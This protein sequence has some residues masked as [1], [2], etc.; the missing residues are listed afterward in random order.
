MI[1]KFKEYLMTQNKSHSTIEG[2]IRSIKDYF[3]WFSHS[4]GKE[5]TKLIKQNID[6][7]RSYLQ[8]IKRQNAK[9]INYKLSSLKKYNEFLVDS[10]IQND[11]IITDKMM[12]KVQQEYASPATITEKDVNQLRQAILEQGSKRDYAL[13]NLLAYTGLRISEAL[14][15]PLSE[16][17]NIYQT[18]ELMIRNGKGNKQRTVY[19]NDKVLSSLKDYI[20]NERSTYKTALDSTF[21][22]VSNKNSC[23]D[24]ITVNKMLDKYCKGAK[25]K[26][27]TPH[28]LR[29]F[30]C[31]HALEKGLTVAEVANIAG[32]S[33][34][35]TTL[36]YTNPSRTKMIEK[37][38]SL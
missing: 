17:N 29:H 19:L 12:L 18:K 10:G 13:I 8:T 31:S 1:D 27:I 26:S 2:Y 35:H 33:N 24:R 16:C 20:T 15:I 3:T 22:F 36:I 14:S 28:Q 23:L 7:F 6:E 30:F 5:P 37:V 25:L 32:H 4:Y 34:I 11:I 9:T 21:L 38:N